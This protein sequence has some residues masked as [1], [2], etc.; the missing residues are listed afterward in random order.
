MKS[1]FFTLFFALFMGTLLNGQT[2]A[3][4]KSNTSDPEI[5]KATEALVAKYKLDA[6]QAKQ[7]YQI[8]QRK[9]R[10]MAEIAGFQTSN[11]ALYQI[12]WE[13]VQKGT[14]AGIRRLLNTKEQVDIYQKTQVELRGLRNA[15]SKELYAQK[16][17]KEA[18]K[19]AV[20][21]IYAE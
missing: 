1:R 6:D 10:N 2:T 16:A 15:K 13:N 5:R 11:P 20:L 3:P 7:M 18:V 12:K 17:T 21:A 8:Q 14:W 4:A 9:N 19:A